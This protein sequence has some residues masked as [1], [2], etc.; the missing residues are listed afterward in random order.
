MP[1]K[2]PN[3]HK[4]KVLPKIPPDPT[5]N[6]VNEGTARTNVKIGIARPISS[7]NLLKAVPKPRARGGYYKKNITSPKCSLATNLEPQR[8]GIGNNPY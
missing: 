6:Q 8:E 2:I 5:S 1:R 4:R 7:A 3:P